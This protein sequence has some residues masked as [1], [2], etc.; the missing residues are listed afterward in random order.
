MGTT[1][2]KCGAVLAA[3]LSAP[4]YGLRPFEGT[5]ASVADP[6]TLELEL[7]YLS[8]LRE[9][10]QKSMIAPEAVVNIGLQNGNELVMEGKVRTRINHEADTRR[11][12][13]ENAAVSIKHVHRNGVLQDEP[14]PSIATECGVLFATLQGDRTGATCAGIVSQRLSAATVHLNASVGKNRAGD[15]E[16]SL[17]A[18]ISGPSFGLVRPVFEIFAVRDSTGERTDSAL[19]GLVWVV[20]ETFSFDFGVRKARTEALGATEI[21]A[22]FTWSGPARH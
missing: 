9:G 7:G 20:N 5:D 15:W 18:I 6:G 19:A 3:M 12:T 21:R 16:R 13:F 11:T 17:G 4:A 14:G 8:Y 22:G 1:A 2:F 10:T